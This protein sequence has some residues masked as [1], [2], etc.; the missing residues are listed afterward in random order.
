MTTTLILFALI[1]LG[2]TLAAL[3]SVV[4]GDRPRCAPVSHPVDTRWLPPSRSL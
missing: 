1:A 2:F 3:R 4:T